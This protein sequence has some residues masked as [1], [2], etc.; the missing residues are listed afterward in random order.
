M[1]RICNKWKKNTS[2]RTN[3]WRLKLWSRKKYAS[4][5]KLR[6]WNSKEKWNSWRWKWKKKGWKSSFL[7]KYWGNIG[8]SRRGNKNTWSRMSCWQNKNW[9]ESY[10]RRKK[11]KERCW[12]ISKKII[13]NWSKCSN[14]WKGKMKKLRDRIKRNYCRSEEWRNK[15]ENSSRT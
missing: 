15:Q 8:R 12:R 2:E 4:N 9:R 6:C 7:R 13:G 11:W 10:W 14:R 3:N 5:N 1:N